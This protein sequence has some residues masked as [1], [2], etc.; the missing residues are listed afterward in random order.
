[1]I[2]H[3]E[4]GIVVFTERHAG[5][6]QFAFDEVMAIEIVGDGKG[7]ERSHEQGDRPQ[8]FV[9]NVEVIVSVAGTLSGEDAVMGIVD[10][11]LGNGGTE[12]G[13]QFHALEDEIDSE[14]MAAFSSLQVGMNVVFLAD[15]FSAHSMGILRF[16]AKASTQRW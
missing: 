7:E 13:S 3:P 10:R 8:H 14:L 2:G 15:P 1:M 12:G 5:A 11:K 9:A 6:L 4:K 16:L